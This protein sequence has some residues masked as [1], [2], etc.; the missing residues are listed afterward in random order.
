MAGKLITMGKVKQILQLSEQ[1]ISQREISRRLQIDRKTIAQYLSKKKEFNYKAEALLSMSDLELEELFKTKVTA[2]DNNEEYLYLS[3]QFP[4][5]KEELKKTGVTRFSLWEE[6]KGIHSEGY[7]YSQ[8]CYHYQQWLVSENVSMRLHHDYGM[9]LFIDFTGKKIPYFSPEL[10]AVTESEVLITIL[11]G[12]GY[13]Y[14]EATGSQKVEDFVLGITNSIHHFGGVSKVFIPDNLKSGVTSANKYQA[15]LNDTFLSMVNH[16]GTTVCPARVRKP[17]DKA[18]VESVVN[19]VYSRV[20]AP[21]RDKLP[22][23]LTELNNA[24]KDLVAIANAKN[25]QGRDYSRL[26]LFQNY[27]KGS[28]MPI[29]MG[30]FELTKSYK[31]KVN[32][33]YHVYF[34][35]DRHSYSVPY[36]YAGKRIKAIASSSIISFYYN[37]IQIA[38][39]LRSNIVND[40]TTKVEHMHPSHKYVKQWEPAAAYAWGSAIDTSVEEYLRNMISKGS[41]PHMARRM[42]EGVVNISKKYGNP[43]LINACKRA[44]SYKVYDYTTLKNIIAN[45]LDLLDQCQR[46]KTTQLPSHA[47]I[48]G[49]KY[50]K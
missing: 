47:N 49:S 46:V 1:G 28:L 37:G 43:R 6:Y 7:G 27:E 19:V 23:G 33:D 22:H 26:D 21:L 9:E 24:I 2:I 32:K 39:H 48:R 16:Y 5:F 8:M 12:S 18:M 38:S 15:V 36:K 34:S 44:L 14:V 3:S 29:T 31:L 13:F 41:Y 50:Y 35:K 25:F 4:R 20:F 40:Y 30:R 45:N 10:N 17:K 11:G 42:F